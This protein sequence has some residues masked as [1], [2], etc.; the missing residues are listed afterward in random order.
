MQTGRPA[1]VGF[2]AGIDIE[3]KKAV[4]NPLPIARVMGTASFL[5]AKEER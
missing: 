5:A 2:A 1:W 4:P 3:F